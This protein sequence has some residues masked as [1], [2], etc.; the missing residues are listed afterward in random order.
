MGGG[1][2]QIRLCSTL[3]FAGAYLAMQTC[4]KIFEAWGTLPMASD[5]EGVVASKDT[6]TPEQKG[7]IKEM[8]AESAE[9]TCSCKA[10][11]HMEVAWPKQMSH[12]AKFGTGMNSEHMPGST[13]RDTNINS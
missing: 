11:A 8:S 3:L 5:V 6:S 2:L 7:L 13:P 1:Y 12:P 9:R 10:E 4:L